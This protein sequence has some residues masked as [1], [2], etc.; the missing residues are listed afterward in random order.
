MKKIFLQGVSFD[1][2]FERWVEFCTQYRGRFFPLFFIMNT[3]KK[4]DIL[5]SIL[6]GNHD[7]VMNMSSWIFL[8]IQHM[9]IN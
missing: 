7:E 1:M 8:S 2:E 9:F 6:N 4:N 5:L 3:N